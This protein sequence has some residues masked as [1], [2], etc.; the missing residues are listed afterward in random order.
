M[1]EL[2]VQPALLSSF[3]V[4][5]AS[6][7]PTMKL[8][9]ET[10]VQQ[11]GWATLLRAAHLP[12]AFMQNAPSSQSSLLHSTPMCP[13]VYSPLPG[14]RHAALLCSKGPLGQ[15]E[16]SKAGGWRENLEALTTAANG[17][18]ERE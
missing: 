10:A 12:D 3:R 11:P 18:M 13:Q 2:V 14:P 15:G 1:R 8:S 5:R 6:R 9:T 16:A 4:K 17:R 7:H